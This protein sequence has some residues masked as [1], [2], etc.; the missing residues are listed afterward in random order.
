MRGDAMLRCSRKRSESDRYTTQT[1]QNTTRNATQRNRQRT[2]AI[3]H[4]MQHQL[5]GRGD[6][7]G[8]GDGDRMIMMKRSA[9]KGRR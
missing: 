9:S 3:V 2:S 5:I 7:D 8:D 1:K 6:G 4:E